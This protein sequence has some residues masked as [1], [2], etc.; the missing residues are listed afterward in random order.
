VLEAATLRGA[1]SWPGRS[2]GGGIGAALTSVAGSSRDQARAWF[3]RDHAFLRARVYPVLK[4]AVA[5]FDDYLHEDETGHLLTGPSVSPELSYLL[6]DGTPAAICMAPAMDCEILDE[7]FGAFVQASLLLEEDGDLR[8]HVQQMKEK[9]P[10]PKI[11]EHGRLLEWQHD[12][13]EK[14]SGHR[15]ISHLFSTFPGTGVDPDAT[16]ELAAAV[17][18]SLER[19]IENGGGKSGWSSSW[20]SCV[21]ARLRNG[22]GAYKQ[23]M[24]VMR[25][26]IYG[27]LFSG[28]PP[29]V[30]QID[31]NF[32]A[33]AA[34][35]EMLL[36]SHRDVIH[37]LP[38]LPPAWSSGSVSGLRARGGFEVD[39]A[40]TEGR[41][42]TGRVKSEHGAP[43]SLRCA[44]GVTVRRDGVDVSVT[45][46]GDSLRFDTEPGAVYEIVAR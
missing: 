3:T 20:I 26:W 46:N 22:E 34:V 15:H 42:S 30:F 31:G 8:N 17:R 11:G 32:G 38:A 44:T 45:A 23:L 19:R 28:H 29:G 18:A 13:P 41:L 16:P 10:P 4:E 6:E 1:R 24:N 43:C 7:L 35:A 36:Q 12:F 39:M 27:N 25:G 21:W 9:L 14:E 2:T 5:F 37:L 33:C 40:W